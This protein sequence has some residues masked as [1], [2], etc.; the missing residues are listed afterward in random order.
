MSLRMTI[1]QFEE[2][3]LFSNRNI[4]K[5]VA[6]VVNESSNAAL[7]SMFEDSVILLDHE[8][9][10]FYAA[11]YTFDGKKLKLT[12]ENFQPID[13]EK[14]ESNFKNDVSKFFES[15]ETS[16]TSLTE[17]Y[18]DSV[19]DQEKFVN[20]LISEALS[21]KNFEDNVSYKELSEANDG[22][23]IADKPYFKAYQERLET[24]PLNEAKFFNWKDKVVVSLLESE[25]VKL[26]NS[27]A[28]EKAADLWKKEIFKKS[29]NEAASLFIKDV[30]AGKEKF[31][32]LFEEYP[33]LFLLDNA[34]R[35]TLFGKAIIASS[36]LREHLD[37]LQKGMN[38]LL[39]DEDV[40]SIKES[41]LSL[42][43][44]SDDEES[45]EE[46]EEEE[47]DDEEDDEEE[48]DEP[49]KELDADEI[50]E[51]A[52][53]IKKVAGKVEDEDLKEKLKKLAD[54]LEKSIEEGTRPDLIKEA[55]YL[56]S[57]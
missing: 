36:A 48:K 56:L 30:E 51:I 26:I 24:N 8:D 33:Q 14:E 55:V 10:Q 12:L 41:Y 21:T 20:E 23:S 47:E 40:K 43:N 35:K 4:E 37:D 16:A 46:E 27:S 42:I 32:S 31:V 15:D 19:L 54:K 17:S 57:I 1:K 18:K 50:G 25:K 52:D 7:V 22:I 3:N 29:F 9:G 49:A 38:I 34:D 11:D 39:E 13:L 44:E 53:E 45:E 5:V 6:S 28:A 2:L